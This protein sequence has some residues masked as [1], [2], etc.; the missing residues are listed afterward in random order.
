[1]PYEWDDWALAALLGIEQHEVRQALEARRRWP[2]RAVS[3]TGVPVLTVWS[4]TASGRPLIVAVYH[5]AGY[6]WK[7]IGARD[8]AD[9]ELIEFSRWE[10]TQ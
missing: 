8:M 5:T 3:A 10:E 6:T 9:K 7:I 4:R 1:M 2:R